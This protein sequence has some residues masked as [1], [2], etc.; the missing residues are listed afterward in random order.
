MFGKP[1]KPVRPGASGE[2]FGLESG[3]AAA[4]DPGGDEIPCPSCGRPM[5]AEWGITC[6]Q[7]RPG[8]V[9]P[10]TLAISGSAAAA[11]RQL[12]M[13]ESMAL[14]WLV[15]LRSPDVPLVGQ[16]FEVDTPVMVLSRRSG[17]LGRGRLELADDFMSTEHATIRRPTAADGRQPFTIAD[18]ES[19]APSVN[20]TRVNSHRLTP[21]E[22]LALSDGDYLHLGTT[23]FVFKTLWLPPAGAPPRS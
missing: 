12:V 20:G 4:R 19:P 9:A 17:R 18:R 6:G 13:S 5:L 23:E 21:G 8:L 2:A 14:G 22:V 3:G 1:R 10:K 7:C 16:V 15:V 11:V